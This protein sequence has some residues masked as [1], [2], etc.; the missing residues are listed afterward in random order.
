MR[1]LTRPLPVSSYLIAG[2][3]TN[4]ELY[5]SYIYIYS[6]YT[7]PPLP[8]VPG[9]SYSWRRRGKRTQQVGMLVAGPFDL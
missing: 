6:V 8:Y 2:T 9:G 7:P 1:G 3:V 5:R 4:T